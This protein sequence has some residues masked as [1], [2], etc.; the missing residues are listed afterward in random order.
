MAA[1]SCA[2]VDINPHVKFVGVSKLR[3]LNATKLRE[4]TEDTFVIQEND[5]PLSVLLSY[6][7]YLQMREE[8]NQLL[9]MIEMLSNDQE[10]SG[11]LAAFEDI[12]AGRVRSLAEIEADL[13][14]E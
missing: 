5:T 3:D 7:R 10:R 11:I 13:E 9:N 12:R 4:Q 1:P 6:Q 14:N 8:F 2:F